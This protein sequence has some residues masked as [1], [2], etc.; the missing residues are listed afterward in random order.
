MVL[1][2]FLVFS[3]KRTKI[4]NH[5][6]EGG[7]SSEGWV[8]DDTLEVGKWIYYDRYPNVTAIVKRN[9]K[10]KRHG[11]RKIFFLT[12][13]LSSKN[14]F[15]NGKREGKQ[16]HYY[17]TGED[18]LVYYCRNDTIIKESYKLYDKKGNLIEN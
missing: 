9:R 13:E 12:G 14:R 8:I 5:Y 10:G 6:P 1:I 3:C 2:L 4:I 17:K 18:S 7:I 11:I 15:R 16:V